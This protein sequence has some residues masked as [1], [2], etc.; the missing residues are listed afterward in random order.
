MESLLPTL[1]LWMIAH[2]ISSGLAYLVVIPAYFKQV[3]TN[4]NGCYCILAM[5]FE[6]LNVF[7][8]MVALILHLV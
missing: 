8:C 7:V 5:K 1:P 2:E 4:G 6:I 3:L